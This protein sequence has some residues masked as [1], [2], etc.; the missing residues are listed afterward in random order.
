M[1]RFASYVRLDPVPYIR[2]TDQNLSRA[3]WGDGI[4]I[5]DEE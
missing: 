1:Q 2:R 5:Q 3:P 4:G